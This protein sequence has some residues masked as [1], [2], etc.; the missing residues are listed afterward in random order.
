LQYITV[1]GKGFLKP[2]IRS[3]PG[4][5]LLNLQNKPPQPIPGNV[6][7]HLPINLKKV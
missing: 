2:I 1:L 4:M 6:V 3:K 7:M 5:V